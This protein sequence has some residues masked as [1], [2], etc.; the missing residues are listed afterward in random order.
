MLLVSFVIKVKQLLISSLNVLQLSLSGAQW[1]QKLV[2]LT[3]Q[4]TLH[5]SFGSFLVLFQLVEMFK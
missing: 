5:S 2:L 4:G 3:D 1:Q